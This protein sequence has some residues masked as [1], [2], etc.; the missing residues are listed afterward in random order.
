[1]VQTQ[2]LPHELKLT[3]SKLLEL[4]LI[5]PDFIELLINSVAQF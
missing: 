5:T 3:H 1:M 4:T 2:N